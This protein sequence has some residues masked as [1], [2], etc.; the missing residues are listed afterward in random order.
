MKTLKEK[1]VLITGAGRGIGSA[2]AVRCAEQGARIAVNFLKDTVAAE[3]TLNRI[4]QVGGEGILIQADVRDPNQAHRLVEATAG[5]FGGLDVLVNNA[6]TPFQRLGIS[7]LTWE[8]MQ[9]QLHGTLRSS[10]NCVRSAL[11]HLAVSDCS[12]ILNISSVTVRLPERGYAHRNIAKAALEEYTQCLAVELCEMGIRVNALSVGWTETDQC[13]DFSESYLE[14]KRREIPQGRFASPSEIA[15]VAAF[16]ISSASSYMTGT[17][18]PVAGG[19]SPSV[20]AI[21]ETTL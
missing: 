5:A 16:M 15:E 12:S 11:A 14:Q 1:V 21:E 19:L 9:E 8:Q 20:Q 3:G 6:H 10:F 4:R 17:V 18:L 2:I 7:E 13:A